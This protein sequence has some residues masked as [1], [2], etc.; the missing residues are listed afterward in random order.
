MFDPDRAGGKRPV[1]AGIETNCEIV[2]GTENQRD[3]IALSD[4]NGT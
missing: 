1:A 2:F 4:Q 3:F